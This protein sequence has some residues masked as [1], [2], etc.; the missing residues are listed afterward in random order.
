MTTIADPRQDEI[1]AFWTEAR[2]RANL[3]RLE[4]YCGPTELDSLQPPASSFGGSREVADKLADLI[5]AGTKT[6][7]S[8][9]V[10]DWE[11]DGDDLPRRGDLEI[12]LDGSGHPRA[13]IVTTAVEIVPFDEVDAEHARLE[14]EGDQSLDHWR[15]VHE[16]F[17]TEHAAHDH[18]FASDMPIVCQRF[19]VLHSRKR[20]AG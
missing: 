2:M 10:W 7:T 20:P 19:E 4:V 18:G 9:A 11:A 16:D 5:V 3:N 1:D 13:L 6:A 14:G 12:V 17:F 8:S 15:A